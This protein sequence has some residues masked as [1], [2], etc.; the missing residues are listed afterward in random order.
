ME[1]ADMLLINKADGENMKPSQKAQL[2]FQHALHLFPPKENQW[3]V[4]VDLC[5]AQEQNGIEKAWMTIQQFFK[6][7][8]INGSFDRNRKSQNLHWF[9]EALRM[10]LEDQFFRQPRIKAEL[11]DI[12]SKI[13]QGELS[14]RKAIEQLLK[15]E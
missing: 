5:S 7:T 13:A 11:P 10:H 1:M 15:P 6:L 2:E 9:R 8:R 14:L 4:P 12:E 3:T